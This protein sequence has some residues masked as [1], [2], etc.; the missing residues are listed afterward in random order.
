MTPS[1][2]SINLL[3]QVTEFAETF[4]SLSDWTII[5]GYNAGIARWKRSKGQGR[6]QGVEF[7][8]LCK[9]VPFSPN[10]PALTSQEA[11]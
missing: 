2:G 8:V 6:E 11:L 10:L 9:S 3:E 4:Y 5:K 7:P 1:L